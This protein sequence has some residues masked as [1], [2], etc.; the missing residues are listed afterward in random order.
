MSLVDILSR[1]LSAINT[2]TLR[3]HI[4]NCKTVQYKQQSIFS[5]I[6]TSLATHYLS[7]NVVVM[8]KRKVIFLISR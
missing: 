2:L 5:P 4:F 8:L 7:N 1:T 3:G 6:R